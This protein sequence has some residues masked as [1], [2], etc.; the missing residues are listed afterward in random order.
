MAGRQRWAPA[1]GST[2]C[3]T[4]ADTETAIDEQAQSPS[5]VEVSGRQ[6]HMEAGSTIVAKGGEVSLTARQNPGLA[7][8]GRH[9]AAARR[10]RMPASGSMRAAS[11]TCPAPRRRRP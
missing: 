6:I 9:H 4:L 5:R 7:R 10:S 11:L 1:A 2:S 8:P 3:P